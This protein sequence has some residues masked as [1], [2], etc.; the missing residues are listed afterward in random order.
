MK[1]NSLKLAGR[2]RETGRTQESL[3]NEVGVSRRTIVH[4]IRTGEIARTDTLIRIAE[5]LNLRMADLLEGM[6]SA[7]SQ[8]FADK[9][10]IKAPSQV[11]EINN[12]WMIPLSAQGVFLS[13]NSRIRK[14][15]MRI[16]FP[17]F[18]SECFAFEVEGHDMF[19][20]SDPEGSF[21]AGSWV[22]ATRTEVAS[23]RLGIAYVLQ[24]RSGI[25]IRIVE[26]VKD[27]LIDLVSLSGQKSALAFSQVEQ[28]YNIELRIGRAKTNWHSLIASKGL[29]VN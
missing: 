17:F 12:L 15:V 29:S 25:I 23:L 18:K 4:I 5:V 6:D 7:E 24:Y 22:I 27:G 3:A 16:P 13:E 10:M 19:L 21:P 11:G 1:I 14:A 2:I 20:A 8:S 9:A 28:V 26:N